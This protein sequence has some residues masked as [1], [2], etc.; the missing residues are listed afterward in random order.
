MADKCPEKAFSKTMFNLYLSRCIG[1]VE[2]GYASHPQNPTGF[3]IDSI[4]H[5]PGAFEALVDMIVDYAHLN[6]NT[7]TVKQQAIN[8]MTT[9]ITKHFSTENYKENTKGNYKLIFNT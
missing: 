6:Q 3:N 7:Q 4:N 5:L 8:N 9:A 1:E 2:R